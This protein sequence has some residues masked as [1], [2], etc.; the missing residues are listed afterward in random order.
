MTDYTARPNRMNVSGAL[1]D[2]WAHTRR[3]L[4]PFRFE[5]WISLGVIVFI[6]AL[7]QGGG[8]GM[9]NFNFPSEGAEGQDVSQGIR[10]ALDVLQE[11][12]AVILLVAVIVMA[13]VVG[14]VLLFTWLGSRGTMM[15]VRAVATTD[16]RIG[17]NWRAVRD[18]AWSLFLFRLVLALIGL[19]G[20]FGLVVLAAVVAIP[21][22]QRDTADIGS[23][24]LALMP[25]ALA[26]GLFVLILWLVNTLTRNFVAPLMFL[27]GV[28]AL[29]GWRRFRVVSRGN[30][31][32]I[33]LFLLIR[34]AYHVAYSIAVFLTCLV[35]CCIGVLPVIHQALFAPFYVFDRAFSLFLLGSAGPEYAMV[36]P[37]PDPETPE[38]YEPAPLLDEFP[39]R[40]PGRTTPPPPRSDA[41]PTDDD[42]FRSPFEDRDEDRDRP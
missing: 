18:T 16:H 3:M 7:G 30:I 9:S 8:G 1:S 14:L 28:S 4:F 23:Y 42:P 5:V 19:I 22:A 32:P 24:F 38:R 6:E 33:V 13:L 36:V 41:P 10:N 27:G 11:N 35:T 34:L 31:G 37:L 40:L 26:F 25:V 17:E 12:L 29:E 2:A 39:E 20:A 15:L 21:L